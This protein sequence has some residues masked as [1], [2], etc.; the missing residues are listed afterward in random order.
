MSDDPAASA[1]TRHGPEHVLGDGRGERTSVITIGLAALTLAVAGMAVSF[2]VVDRE[3][4]SYFG[5]LAFAVPLGVDLAILVFSSADLLQ[6][7]WRMNIRW[8]RLAP[9][10]FTAATVYMNVNAGGPGAVLVA[11]AAMPSLWVLFIEFV[12]ALIRFRITQV[13]QLADKDIPIARWILAPWTT[14]KLW[15]RMKLWTVDSY[16]EALTLEAQRIARSVYLEHAY[17]SRWLANA[18]PQEVLA[19]RLLRIAPVNVAGPVLARLFEEGFTLTSLLSDLDRSPA[20][21]RAARPTPPMS[22]ETTGVAPS[23]RSA[24]HG[25]TLT[26]QDGRREDGGPAVA[27]YFAQGRRDLPKMRR[28]ALTVWV[29]YRNAGRVLTARRLAELSGYSTRQ[30]SRRLDELIGVYGAIAVAVDED[31]ETFAKD[32]AERL[33]GGLELAPDDEPAQTTG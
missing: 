31:D 21:P 22:A 17:G 30:A 18:P 6:T 8:V 3:M 1:G 15:R 28:D 10:A 27:D 29:A 23:R 11:H 4:A 32:L 26:G 12:R 13:D 20:R 19:E 9:A 33:A 7:Y 2:A 5:R 25:S 14:W 24:E 16:R